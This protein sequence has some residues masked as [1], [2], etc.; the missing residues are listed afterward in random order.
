MSGNCYP[1]C[2]SDRDCNYY[3]ETKCISGV[4]SVECYTNE[5]C[6][7]NQYCSSSQGACMTKCQTKRECASNQHCYS[8]VCEL[9]CKNDTGC[10][11]G[12]LCHQENCIPTCNEDSSCADICVHGLCAEG[13][14][15]GAVCPLGKD[16]Q[17]DKCLAYCG[18]ATPCPNNQ[19][20]TQGYCVEECEP[21]DDGCRDECFENRQCA[22][23]HH[24][25]EGT[26]T[27]PCAQNSDC[28][29]G[30]L[31]NQGSCAI[32]CSEEDRIF[33]PYELY[34]GVDG[35]CKSLSGSPCS[36]SADCPSNQYCSDVGCRDSVRHGSACV[37]D[38][39]CGK[40]ELCHE[41]RCE[42]LRGA[43]SRCVEYPI[44]CD[45]KNPNSTSV[46]TCSKLLPNSV[47]DK[48]TSWCSCEEPE[49]Q[50]LGDRC[51]SP[52][53]DV[54]TTTCP[55]SAECRGYRCYH[56]CG[57]N[58]ASCP[59]GLTCANGYCDYPCTEDSNCNF[60]Q[61]C[62]C[63]TCTHTC[64]NDRQCLINQRCNNGVCREAY[65]AKICDSNNNDGNCSA[66]TSCST[67]DFTCQNDVCLRFCDTT[68]SC[69]QSPGEALAKCGCPQPVITYEECLIYDIYCPP[70]TYSPGGFTLIDVRK[71]EECDDLLS[72]SQCSSDGS[73]CLCEPGLVQYAGAVCQALLDAPNPACK[74]GEQQCA[75][76]VAEVCEDGICECIEGMRRSHVTGNCEWLLDKVC[77]RCEPCESNIECGNH[78]VCSRRTSLCI[79]E[80]GYELN[81][82]GLTCSLDRSS[83]SEIDCA[84]HSDCRLLPHSV[85]NLEE[86]KCQCIIDHCYKEKYCKR[87]VNE[88]LGVECL[89]S[90]GF[91]QVCVDV[92]CSSSSS[93]TCVPEIYTN[94]IP[95]TDIKCT[96]NSDCDTDD[97]LGRFGY[98]FADRCTC[99]RGSALLIDGVCVQVGY[100][101]KPN[102]CAAYQ[103]CQHGFCVEKN[104]FT[105]GA[106]MESNESEGDDSG[107][108]DLIGIIIAAAM[109]CAIVALIVASVYMRREYKKKNETE[110]DDR[111]MS[112]KI[113]MK[114]SQIA[115]KK[116]LVRE[117]KEEIQNKQ[118][119]S[120]NLVYPDA[121]NAYNS[122]EADMD[123]VSLKFNDDSHN[124]V[125]PLKAK[126]K[127]KLKKTKSS[128]STTDEAPKKGKSVSKRKSAA[129]EESEPEPEPEADE[130]IA[131]SPWQNATPAQAKKKKP[132]K[133]KTKAAP[134][135]D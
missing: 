127:S 32:A 93:S 70:T 74:I 132:K 83:I 112:Y 15:Q 56:L 82:D 48:S 4:C 120:A 45:S 101:S 69:R 65:C 52:A 7:R 126:K 43:N 35:Y 13:C 60:G 124:D 102:E 87:D 99:R 97:K 30:Y 104:S 63:G 59:S 46:E 119:S 95:T 105:L 77:Q 122:A 62:E 118:M 80:D 37:T 121:K 57:Q 100:C 81:E 66:S 73:T 88:C 26:C 23:K 5:D 107:G 58:R 29:S 10:P 28:G 103:T 71:A 2:E 128:L 54:C 123:D 25:F 78:M 11:F 108:M 85:C 44:S 16:C 96:V 34:C 42:C 116:Y 1:H 110:F 94:S 14:S 64:I 114:K 21:T 51:V 129:K 89:D 49:Y 3:P 115:G 84:R 40:D 109:G 38:D 61:K 12:N 39:E 98:C 22:D 76:R 18:P 27:G 91:A 134:V 133:I 41:R 55:E 8:N 75:S 111:D 36:S 90:N 17:N 31:C 19:V 131:S 33:C 72:N 20:C 6:D 135:L 53:A 130:Y 67:P 47:C 117:K 68:A 86:G 79:C 113:E 92:D 24:C 9:P 50:R 106:F 125:K